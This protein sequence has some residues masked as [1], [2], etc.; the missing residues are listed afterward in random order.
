MCFCRLRKNSI[1]KYW[2]RS[3]FNDKS[4]RILSTSLSHHNNRCKNLIQIDLKKKQSKKYQRIKANNLRRPSKIKVF[5]KAKINKL[6]IFGL[7]KGNKKLC[8]F[9]LLFCLFLDKAITLKLP[10]TKNLFR[11]RFQNKQLNKRKLW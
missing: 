5:N 3:V 10:N 7:E 4:K 6:M 9:L 2:G 8:L 11:T 1:G